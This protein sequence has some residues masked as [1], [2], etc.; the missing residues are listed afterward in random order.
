MSN[1]ISVFSVS[2]SR[3][4]RFLEQSSLIKYLSITRQLQGIFAA[5]QTVGLQTETESPY[6]DDTPV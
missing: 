4:R 3:E 2:S 6:A 5:L 1:D